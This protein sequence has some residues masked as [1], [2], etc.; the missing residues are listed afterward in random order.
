MEKKLDG[1]YTRMLWAILNKTWR[2]HPTKQ[3]LYGHLLPITK[4]IQVRQTRHTGH[5]WRS[6]DEL[7]NDIRLWT[8][9]HGWAKTGQ[10]TET[11]IQQLCANT[12]CSLED[13]TRVM[14]D[15]DGWWE[16]VRDLCWWQQDL[17][18]D[19][20]FY[21]AIMNICGLKEDNDKKAAYKVV[22]GLFNT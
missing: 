3:Q 10:P 14:G 6:G 2:Q 9:S 5:C 13:L 12:R 18:S 20:E 22:F 11:Y 4:T 16:R 8:P 19:T 21:W 17:Q 15:R 1:N 7:I